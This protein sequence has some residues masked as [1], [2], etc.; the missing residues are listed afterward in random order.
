[1]AASTSTLRLIIQALDEFSVELTKLS[2]MVDEVA[3]NIGSVNQKAD[4][5]AKSLTNMAQTATA[6]QQLGV[7]LTA[8]GAAITASVIIP[9]QAAG[10]FERALDRVVAVTEGAQG[11]FAALERTASELGR[12]TRYTATQAAEGM[13]F[14]GMAGFDAAETMSAIGPAL[15]LAAAGQLSLADAADIST[16]IMTAMRVPVEELSHVVDVLAKTST[17][18]NTSVIQMAEALK[19]TAPL[20]QSA[21]V[22]LEQVSAAIGVLGNNGIQA[23]LA[24]TSLRGMLLSLAAPSDKAR[25]TLAKMGVVIARNND[26]SINFIETL[27]RLRD[28]NITLAESNDLFLRR[29]AA[30]ALALAQQVDEVEDLTDA[31]INAVRSGTEMYRLM[32]GNLV[33]AVILLKSAFN[34]LIRSI[35]KPLLA[36]LEAFVRA[37]AK[38]LSSVAETISE[39]PTLTRLITAA[40][41]A[42]GAL[43]TAAGIAAL[44]MSKYVQAARSAIAIN[45]ASYLTTISTAMKS[46]AASTWA[47]TTSLTSLTTI[48]SKLKY[49]WAGLVAV[50]ETLAAAIVANP[51]GAAVIAIISVIALW[52]GQNTLLKKST[53]SLIDSQK[54]LA[55]ELDKTKKTYNDLTKALKA[56]E[57][58]TDQYAEITLKLRNY[59]KETAEE[60]KALELVALEAANSIDILTGEI[61][62]NSDALERYNAALVEQK[63]QNMVRQMR[64]Y[65]QA[66]AEASGEGFWSSIGSGV[67][68]AVDGIRTALSW[69]DKAG[70]LMGNYTNYIKK[71]KDEHTLA[72]RI[73]IE[74]T[75]AFADEMIASFDKMGQIDPNWT[76]EQLIAILDQLG[77]K[78]KETIDLFISRFEH[79]QSE[80]NRMNQSMLE[81]T[82][83]I[84]DATVLHYTETI[85]KLIMESQRLR[86]GLSEAIAEGNREA[87]EQLNV[88]LEENRGAQSEAAA[89][90]DAAIM[91]RRVEDL[92][93]NIKE[94]DVLYKE[95]Q[96]LIK[97]ASDENTKNLT[98]AAQA[99]QALTQ[100]T[101]R[102]AL[103]EKE[104]E[105]NKQL[106]IIRE[107]GIA[108][109]TK[110]GEEKTKAIERALQL[111]EVSAEEGERR[112][113][114]IASEGVEQRLALAR[115]ELSLMVEILGPKSPFLA[116]RI[117]AVQDAEDAVIEARE[118]AANYELKM[119]NKNA[120]KL[121]KAA[122]RAEKAKLR[123]LP[124]DTDK[125]RRQADEELRIIEKS[126]GDKLK[127]G[128]RYEKLREA[129]LKKLKA[130]EARYLKDPEGKK[131]AL[132]AVQ[133]DIAR[134]EKANKIY[135]DAQETYQ[136]L[137]ADVIEKY[138]IKENKYLAKMNDKALKAE[139]ERRRAELEILKKQKDDELAI[140]SEKYQIGEISLEEH[141]NNRRRIIS[142]KIDAEINLL[143]AKLAAAKTNEEKLT[144][145]AQ[146]K[147]KR[148]EETIRTGKEDRDE[149]RAKIQNERAIQ[150]SLIDIR[151]KSLEKWEYTERAQIE[152]VALKQRQKSELDAFNR[153][154]Q[155]VLDAGKSWEDA[156]TEYSTGQSEER[157]QFYRDKLIELGQQGFDEAGFDQTPEERSAT[158]S[159]T[160]LPPEFEGTDALKQKEDE[161]SFQ[162]TVIPEA[163]FEQILANERDA[164]LNS[165]D[166]RLAA[167]M[168]FT[169]DVTKQAEYSAKIQTQKAEVV[170]DHENKVLQE[171]LNLSGKFFGDMSSMFGSLYE[172]SGKELTTFAKL[173]KATAISQ[174]IIETYKAAQQA[175]AAMSGVPYVGPALGAAAAAAAI[176]A[177]MARV[178]AIQAQPLATGGEVEKSPD[179]AG[180]VKLGKKQVPIRITAKEWKFPKERIEQYGP[181][182]FESLKDKA[183]PKVLADLMLQRRKAKGWA[184]RTRAYGEVKGFSPHSKAD[185]IRDFAEPGDYVLPVDT[186]KTYGKNFL[187]ALSKGTLPDN[188]IELFLERRRGYSDGG[189]IGGSS[190]HSKA[191]NVPIWA[192]AKEWVMPVQT[193][194]HYGKDVMAAIQKGLVPAEIF[195]S[196]KLPTINIPTPPKQAYAMGGPITPASSSQPTTTD[197]IPKATRTAM[198]KSQEQ[199]PEEKEEIAIYNVIDPRDMD[200]WASSS[201]GQRAILNI[202]SS[203]SSTVRRILR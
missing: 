194:E 120:D 162:R 138:R 99:E 112:K 185:N 164:E 169:D 10:E 36:P 25:N 147:V 9:V 90:R 201:S 113:L 94:L 106:E 200:R 88:A 23:S 32:E 19:Y 79:W 11:A 183:F 31:N 5:G 202:I 91:N 28:A 180:V 184:K 52:V 59:L 125:F 67:G 46:A 97:V 182:L 181:E 44:A 37:L 135:L 178:Y 177:G 148:T 188:W 197:P 55:A 109:L 122:E 89:N 54:K 136:K 34:G 114:D 43:A 141:Y 101:K 142:E 49:L 81:D 107:L 186:A 153:R 62:K 73:M 195:K 85:N 157:A 119:L 203:R 39:Y 104:K 6:F 18:S 51:I 105:V 38:V 53:E 160:F 187:S 16:N 48:L 171:R 69:L 61:D 168:K 68:I 95:H 102:T 137:R 175:Y 156:L 123:E 76:H 33:G 70:G 2:G 74:K 131:A 152:E 173:Q 78:N 92:K 193:V 140:S 84:N 126:F 20:A 158:L 82:K 29:S 17:S 21:G 66:M 172:A 35:G 77:I 134:I 100:A 40:A 155:D 146:I 87:Q 115:K 3:D 71:T 41:L 149:G 22:T 27:K 130:R 50:L 143:Y 170:K 118:K 98:K 93:K 58:G 64:L 83:G 42:F 176:A 47:F 14:L 116:A 167:Y 4:E 60:N 96:A 192:T 13:R 80:H 26:G 103:V 161:L 198:K 108:Q 65:S 124:D 117:K 145:T 72:M 189:E 132:K 12:T 166:Q 144:I 8:V 86:V 121:G 111:D 63:L 129:Q 7:A 165:L 151:R 1:M 163:D 75:K 24:G 174:T 196:I 128:E 45:M 150:N 15:E 57:E 30:G 133:D 154:K 199:L 56:N 139:L 159:T 127:V 190:P 191:D 110:S 179:I